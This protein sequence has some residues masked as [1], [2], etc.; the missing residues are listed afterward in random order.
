MHSELLS[1]GSERPAAQ[2]SRHLQGA[3]TG[4]EDH[5]SW[6]RQT[7]NDAIT[8]PSAATALEHGDDTA[9]TRPDESGLVGAA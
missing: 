7:T 4:S 6:D 2:Q 9:R 1:S 3:L 8:A 5:E